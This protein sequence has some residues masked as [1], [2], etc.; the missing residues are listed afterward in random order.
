MNAQS[1]RPSVCPMFHLRN[2]L[3]DFDKF[4]TGVLHY[5]LSRELSFNWYRILDEILIELHRFPTYGSPKREDVHNT[6][7]N[8]YDRQFFCNYLRK[9]KQKQFLIMYKQS[10]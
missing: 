4:D 3:S 8:N 6:N 2:H 5:I 7:R 1:G 10:E 9:H